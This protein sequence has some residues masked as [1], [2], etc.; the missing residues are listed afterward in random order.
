L[1]YI[2]SAK[3]DKKVHVDNLIE[4]LQTND[5]VD[6]YW[7]NEL[8]NLL[9]NSVEM[10]PVLRPVAGYI[11]E[12]MSQFLASLGGDPRLK[13]KKE[14]ID[15]IDQFENLNKIIKSKN[16][17]NITNQNQSKDSTKFSSGKTS[18]LSNLSITS[19]NDNEFAKVKFQDLD[20]ETTIALLIHLGCPQDFESRILNLSYT[21]NSFNGNLLSFINDEKEFIE[22][23]GL[24]DVKGLII[25]KVFSDLQKFKSVGIEEKQIL[26]IMRLR[27]A[28][29]AKADKDKEAADKAKAKADKDKE[30]A[31]KAKADKEAADQAKA[32]ADKDKEAADKAKA[33]ADKEAA[34]KAKADKEAADKAKADWEASDKSQIEANKKTKVVI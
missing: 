34:D 11:Y 14:D 31:D 4:S 1:R 27:A 24:Q 16:K 9:T 17:L 25:R 21:K 26:E 2:P 3:T 18:S 29:K 32:K 30:T 13:I 20:Y 6:K 8:R 19:S 33:K 23:F 12:K 10:N 7:I 28:D 5:K 22:E 15:M